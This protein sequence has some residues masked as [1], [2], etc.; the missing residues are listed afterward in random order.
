MKTKT[1]LINSLYSPIPKF[2]FNMVL[3]KKKILFKRIFLRKYT[4]K[5]FTLNIKKYLNKNKVLE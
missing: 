1:D 5:W 4:E 2:T 3:Y